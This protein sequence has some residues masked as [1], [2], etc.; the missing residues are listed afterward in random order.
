[1]TTEGLLEPLPLELLEADEAED[2]SEVVALSEDCALA[3]R[4]R[5]AAS[6]RLRGC[7]LAMLVVRERENDLLHQPVVN[8]C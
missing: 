6:Q 8:E 5:T 1:M 3:P 4:A 2:T 7:I